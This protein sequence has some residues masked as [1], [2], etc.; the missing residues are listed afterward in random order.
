MKY[1]QMI[2][3]VFTRAVS[4]GWLTANIFDSYSCH[5]DEIDQEWLAMDDM[6]RLKDH[7]FGRPQLNEVRDVYVFASFTGYAYAELDSAAPTDLRVGVDGK[8]WISKDRQKTGTDETL[9]LLPIALGIIKRYK[10]HSTCLRRG[11]L[12]PVP[13]CEEYNRCLKEIGSELGL[14]IQLT[15]HKARYFFANV[16]A[17]DNGVEL[18]ITGQ[19]MGQKSLKTTAKYVRKNKRLLAENMKAVE[20]KLFHPDGTLRDKKLPPKHQGKVITLRVV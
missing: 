14:K 10:N 7:T 1:V 11:T 16:V 3:E 15:T 5:Y 17:D 4:I 2:K 20:D 19:L 6:F 13:S 8:Q 9:P 12:L 18:R